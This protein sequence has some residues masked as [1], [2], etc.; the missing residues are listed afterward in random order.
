MI[1]AGRCRLGKRLRSLS[2]ARGCL[3]VVSSEGGRVR[4]RGGTNGPMRRHAVSGRRGSVCTGERARVG[5]GVSCVEGLKLTRNRSLKSNMINRIG[6]TSS[7][8]STKLG[9]D[10]SGSRTG[11]T[12]SGSSISRSCGT[13]DEGTNGPPIVGAG[14]KGRLASNVREV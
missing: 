6:L 11:T 8:P 1:G 9:R 5:M 4:H 7:A 14:R 13:V 3:G 2:S 10:G 12:N